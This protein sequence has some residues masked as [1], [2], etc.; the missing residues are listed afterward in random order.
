MG[1]LQLLAS[2]N[3]SI[4]NKDLA[5]LLGLKEAIF[6][7]ELCSEYDFWARK[8][9]LKD[10]FFYSTVENIQENTTLSE[11]QQNS[12]LNKLMSLNIVERKLI[13]M[14]AKRYFRLNEEKIMDIFYETN[15]LENSGTYPKKLRNLPQETQELTLKNS[16]AYPEK[17]R[18]NNN[19]ITNNNKQIIN[20]SNNII[21]SEK[22]N[23]CEIINYL[24]LKA[25]TNYKSTSEK[26][27]KFIRARM[28]EG[29][30]L[31]DFKIVIDKKV[32]DWKNSDM[33]KYLRPETLFGTK[34]ESYLNQPYKQ[35]TTKDLLSSGIITLDDEENEDLPF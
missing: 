25:G 11:Y 19:N 34:F 6:L 9:E 12:I 26:T 23:F 5:K 15:F 7:A 31:E 16:G 35:A 18:T 24:N 13:G 21:L 32:L 28:N 10:G 22:E 3:Y 14:P 17:L 4:F 27:K 20:N 2:N 30:K 1:L 8:G 33:N 29:F